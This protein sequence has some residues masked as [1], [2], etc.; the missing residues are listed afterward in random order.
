MLRISQAMMIAA[1]SCLAI[2]YLA[3]TTMGRLLKSKT[4]RSYWPPTPNRKLAADYKAHYGPDRNYV[5]YGILT[6]AALAFVLISAIAASW[7][8]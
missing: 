3:G 8:H 6:F 5:A 1:L 4:G 2:S 7:S